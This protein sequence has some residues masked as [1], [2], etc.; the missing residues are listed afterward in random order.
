LFVAA[1]KFK[2]KF[3]ISSYQYGILLLVAS[4]CLV[5]GWNDLYKRTIHNKYVLCIVLLAAAYGILPGQRINVAAAGLSL[6][7]GF[8]LFH[9]NFIGAGD[10]KIF[11]A[12]A[13]FVPQHQ[14]FSFLFLTTL[15]GA[16][17]VAIGFVLYRKQMKA[18]GVP[19]GVAISLSFLY[20]MFFF[21][22]GYI[23]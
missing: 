19:Y 16:V 17:I 15:C 2:D 9:A 7:V 21:D 12:L 18:M 3:V 5:I 22:P 13:L 14:F 20:C 10:A 1:G 6:L 4:L 11:S 8:F 23:Q